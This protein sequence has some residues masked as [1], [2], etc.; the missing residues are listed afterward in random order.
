MPVDVIEQIDRDANGSRSAT[1]ALSAAVYVGAWLAGLA[2]GPGTV[3][4]AVPD[5]EVQSH[6]VGSAVVVCAQATLVHLMAGIALMSLVAGVAPLLVGRLTRVGALGAGVAA[7]VLSVLQAVV[8]YLA[9]A[10]A[11]SRPAAWSRT[12]VD[13]VAHL[14]VV[15]ISLLAGFVAIVS[16]AAITVHVPRIVRI[17]GGTTSVMLVL[18]AASFAL[19]GAVLQAALALSLVLLLAW[20][21]TIG[22]TLSRT[23]RA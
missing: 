18:G 1:I 3:G 5:S 9:V 6:F 16:M 2:L 20:V 13:L 14:D 11:G 7:G 4:P 12:M 10:R 21:G 23:N 17:G 15:K 8:A 22:W 19:D